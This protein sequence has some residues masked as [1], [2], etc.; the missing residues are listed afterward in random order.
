MIHS[1]YLIDLQYY[2][3][4]N[5]QY[6]PPPQDYSGEVD[7]ILVFAFSAR[8]AGMYRTG[9]RSCVQAS[10]YIIFTAYI[11]L[12]C[13]GQFLFLPLLSSLSTTDSLDAG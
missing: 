10:L 7:D 8:K 2:S 11:W 3:T 12:G 4:D 5:L 9:F 1:T 13:S 6:Y